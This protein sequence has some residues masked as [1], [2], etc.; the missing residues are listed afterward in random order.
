MLRRILTLSLLI[1]GLVAAAGGLLYG[2]KGSQSKYLH[3]GPTRIVGS[4]SFEILDSGEIEGYFAVSDGTQFVMAGSDS[5]PAVT[6]LTNLVSA[7]EDG[8]STISLVYRPEITHVDK[9]LDSSTHVRGD[10]HEVV[11][12][13]IRNAGSHV[14]QTATKPEYAQYA[15]P[16]PWLIGLPLVGVGL[17]LCVI[18]L[19]LLMVGARARRRDA[20]GAVA[21]AAPMAQ[22][23]AP[24]QPTSPEPFSQG[25]ATPRQGES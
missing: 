6:D 19:A 21:V 3:I 23:S 18:A 1:V 2:A 11:Q 17:V 9:D 13:T 24:T 14:L 20:S 16:N 7:T 15:P 10:F 5:S 25:P 4:H 22:M 8:S 12:F